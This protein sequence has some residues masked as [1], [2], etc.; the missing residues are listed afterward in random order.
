MIN[1]K[2]RTFCSSAG[3]CANRECYRWLDFGAKYDLPIAM[4][5]MKDTERC[6]GYIEHDVLTTIKAIFG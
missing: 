4:A 2:D 1:H 3:H 5:D 6:E